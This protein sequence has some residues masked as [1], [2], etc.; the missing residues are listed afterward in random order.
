MGDRR[1]VRPV[2]RTLPAVKPG[3]ER[4]VRPYSGL[5]SSAQILDES[6]SRSL[7]IQSTEW[8]TEAWN[9]YRSLGELRFAIRDWFAAGMSRIRLI[10]AVVRP[11]EDPSPVIDGPMADLV[12][13]LAG[14]I[15]GQA[16]MM[17]RLSVHLSVPGD[18][19]LVGEQ[20]YNTVWRVCSAD[21]IRIMQRNVLG[22]DGIY[23]NVYA[24]MEGIN[25]WRTLGPDS[26]VVR[27]WRADDQYAW[28]A[29][30]ACE[31]AIPIMREIDYY[32]RYIVSVL[33]S[34]LA[35]NGVLLIPAE[36]TF[37]A[38]DIYK[39]AEDPFVAELI[40]IATK[41]IQNPG[42]AAAALPIPIK[43][44][45]QYIEMF[46]HLT[47]D[48]IMHEDV[49][50]NRMQAIKRLATSLT[51]P[52]EVLTGEASM[53][54]W[55]RWQMEESAIKLYFS[56][57]AEVICNGLTKGYLLPMA[58]ASGL[59]LV[60]PDGGKYVVWYDTS[61][62]AQTPDRSGTATQL[63]DRGE[64]DGSALR[65]ETGFEEADKPTTEELKTMSLQRIALSAGAGAMD[66]LAK[67]TG[68]ESIA[69]SDTSDS[70]PG[71]EDSLKPG[72][73]VIPDMPSDTRVSSDTVRSV[74]NTRPSMR[75]SGV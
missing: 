63:Y 8:Q 33:L 16:E 50:D 9:F 74:P 3:Y 5:T 70:P 43:V 69:P 6:V 36:V 25:E 45:S 65:R 58:E 73:G 32:N 29:S 34:R 49:L 1:P 59:D 62:L 2:R 31:A 38:K 21:E 10:A 66:A 67:L 39:D 7:L 22:Q 15:G 48:S 75:I 12:A 37:P 52:A 13:N 56:P 64:I 23:R 24:I 27:I 60:A 28:R 42:T 61:A 14:G 53:N 19:Y 11:G 51:I 57:T 68:D 55:G 44:P 18:S 26:L 47:F 40:D 54:H 35:L 41:S 20:D 30:S 71:S 46:K 72:E 4:V 17:T